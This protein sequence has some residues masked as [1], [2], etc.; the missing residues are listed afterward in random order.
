MSLSAISFNQ[1]VSPANGIVISVQCAEMTIPLATC[2]KKPIC[3]SPILA[4]SVLLDDNRC[5]HEWVNLAMV[6]E[7]ASFGEGEAVRAAVGRDGIAGAGVEGGA[8]VAGDGMGRARVVGPGDGRASF[9]GDGGRTEG[10]GA[11]A[12]NRNGHGGTGWCGGRCG[13]IPGGCCGGSIAGLGRCWRR[14]ATSGAAAGRQDDHGR[15]RQQDEQCASTVPFRTSS[16][17]CVQMH[18]FPLLSIY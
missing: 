8:I 12:G 18:C 11:V 4:G 14:A 3:I 2:F 13:G 10:E 9:D 6:G 7:G 16:C 15:E 17:V 1:L 5:L